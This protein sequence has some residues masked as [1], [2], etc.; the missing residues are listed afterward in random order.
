MVEDLETG[1]FFPA[2]TNLGYA[3]TFHAKSEQQHLKIE[4]HLLDFKGDLYGRK[5]R[6]YLM[7]RL[8][9]EIEFPNVEALKTQIQKDLH[10]TR[11][12]FAHLNL[13]HTESTHRGLSLK[14]PAAES[15]SFEGLKFIITLPL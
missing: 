1:L 12:F 3:P 2:A 11:E 6:L 13:L 9:D 5:L 10:S 8:R 7:S 4:P 15:Q 14:S